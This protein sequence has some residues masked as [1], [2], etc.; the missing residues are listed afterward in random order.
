MK[1]RLLI[2]ASTCVVGGGVQVAVGFLHHLYGRL[3]DLNWEVAVLAS[4]DVHDQCAGLPEKEGW[5]TARISPSPASLFGGL[6]SRRAIREVTVGTDDGRV[7]KP[8]EL[9]DA[10]PKIRR[11][12]HGDRKSVV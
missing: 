3:R 6:A 4:P 12:E 5:T 8:A 9:R 11:P 1:R 10:E 7:G 2:N